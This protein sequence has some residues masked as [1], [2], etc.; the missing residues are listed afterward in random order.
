MYRAQNERDTE[1]DE[2]LKSAASKSGRKKSH[3]INEILKQKAE[4][5]DYREY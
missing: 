1:Q 4:E 2:N 3:M 5:K